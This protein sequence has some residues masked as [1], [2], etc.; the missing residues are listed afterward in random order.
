[1]HWIHYKCCMAE[2]KIF[3]VTNNKTW[4]TFHL[5][6]CYSDSTKGKT[7]IYII[8][9]T[10]YIYL[11]NLLYKY[12]LYIYYLLKV[13][14]LY[15]I[16]LFHCMKRGVVER[17]YYLENMKFSWQYLAFSFKYNMIN[18][19]CCHLRFVDVFRKE[20]IATC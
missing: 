17:R 10:L 1:M 14:S 12:I 8:Y 20:N 19:L 6:S 11:L 13:Y 9:I 18:Y 2:Q 5:I 4:R 7:R 16:L 3:S 15:F